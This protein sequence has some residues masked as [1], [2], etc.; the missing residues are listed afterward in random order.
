MTHPFH[1]LAGQE[2]DLISRKRNWGED[3]VF[4][5]GQG[6]LTTSMPATWTDVDP[7]DPC[8]VVSAG[9]TAFRIQD[10]LALAGLLDSLQSR[11]PKEV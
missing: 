1:P 6:G 11:L 8:V 7:P 10:L 4:I 2:F 9:R 5:V 3:R